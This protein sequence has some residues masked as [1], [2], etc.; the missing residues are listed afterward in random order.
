MPTR[1]RKVRSL[2]GSRTYG[3]GRSGQHRAGGGQGG[4]GKAGWKRHK[5]SSVIRYGWTISEKGFKSTNH[6]IDQTINIR[7]LKL[8]M[9]RLLS[10]GFAKQNNGKLEVDLTKAGY[11]KL[12]GDGRIEADRPLRIL[13]AKS[14][15]KAMAK[16]GETGGEVILPSK[17]KEE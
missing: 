5:W 12:L 13:V 1:L 8:Q 6:R 4:H 9:D 14:S 2:R 10:E 11:D 16:I 15:E 3:W 17:G 7:Q